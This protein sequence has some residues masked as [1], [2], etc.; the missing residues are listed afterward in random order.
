MLGIGFD[1]EDDIGFEDDDTV[2]DVW[3]VAECMIIYY[4]WKKKWTRRSLFDDACKYREYSN[5]ETKK[6]TK[7]NKT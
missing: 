3:P 5:K 6:K 1:D 7:I 2:D 4:L